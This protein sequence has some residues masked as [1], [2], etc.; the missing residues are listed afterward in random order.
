M[1][2]CYDYGLVDIGFGLWFQA[3][4]DVSSTSSETSDDDTPLQA[5]V[6][7]RWLT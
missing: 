7:Q 1:D 4:I 5:V 2:I 3:T 6:T